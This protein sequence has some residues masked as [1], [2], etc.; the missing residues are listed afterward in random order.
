MRLL[1]GSDRREYEAQIQELSALRALATTHSQERAQLAARIEELRAAV[2]YQTERA[3]RAMDNL[4]IEKGVAPIMPGDPRSDPD[5]G[6]FDEDPA[7]VEALHAVMQRDGL[8]AGLVIRD[9]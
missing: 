5:L 4:L 1:T 6:M 7:E 2:Q 3:D 9:Q 8:L